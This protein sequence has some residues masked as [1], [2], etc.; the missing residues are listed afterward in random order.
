MGRGRNTLGK[1]TMTNRDNRIMQ[2]VAKCGC[3][4]K[5]LATR[6]CNVS[7]NRLD[8][9]V[10]A[11][12]LRKEN[13]IVCGKATTVYKLDDNGKGYVKGNISTVNNLYKAQ[14]AY[15]DLQ[16]C[17]SFLKLYPEQQDKALTEIDVTKEHGKGINTYT[18]PPDLLVPK[19]E[20]IIDFETRE[21]VVVEM[22]IIEVIT[23]NY[24]KTELQ[25][26]ERYIQENIAVAKEVLK[27]ENARQIKDFLD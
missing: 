5:N 26:K 3:I 24:T 16:L 17:H 20:V 4:N 21:T 8:R 13:V 23:H 27:Y 14:S 15:H 25:A 12:Y 22:E 2:A 11:G 18:S 19:V 7:N 9:M 10:K 1:F 6:Y